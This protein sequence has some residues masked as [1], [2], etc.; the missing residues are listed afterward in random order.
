M[1]LLAASYAAVSAV[2]Y[3][4]DRDSASVLWA[5]GLTLAAIGAATLVSGATL[6]IVWAAEAA[7][8]AWL[9]RRIDEPRFQ[10][11]SLGWLALAFVHALAVDARVTRL[12]VANDHAY[13]AV[14]SVGAL[15][16]AA[17]LIGLSRFE[18]ETRDEGLLARMFSDLR[19]AQ[20]HLH[21]AALV[22]AGATALYAGSL[23]V[24]AMPA[25]WDWGHV[26]VAG[27]WSAVAAGLVVL[28]RK[29]E[30]LALSLAALLL[31]VFYDLPH[32]AET[33]RAWSF[34]CVGAAA[35]V[36]AVWW[37]LRAC[38][39]TM[40]VAALVEL[41]ASVALTTSSVAQLLDGRERG[42]G[43]L[44][45]AAAYG[46]TAVLLLRRRRDFASGLG[47]VALALAVPAS[48]LLLH[49]TWL[50][51]AWAATSAALVVLTR[52]EQ[53]LAYGAL[54]YF[55]LALLHTLALDAPPS[56]LF[57]AH[58]H[59][60]TG[61]PTLA[62]SALA[63]AVL[64]LR[65]P[66]LRRRLGWLAGALGLYAVALA[67]LEASEAIGGGIDTAFQRGHTAVSALWG[68]IGLTLLVAG[69]KRSARHLQFGGFALFGVA[70]AKLFLYD[71]G[72]LS[73]ITR[74]LS[75]LAVGA[76]MIVGGFF[77]QR[78]ALESRT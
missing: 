9:A 34:A 11:A 2:L 12:F 73:S 63:A 24:V 40:E 10:L 8:L 26:A 64:A 69:L 59:P 72:H 42:A 55:G 16:A 33:P 25:S 32:V 71:L 14:P 51:L 43:L 15:A 53:R 22:L 67:L 20:P 56:T 31:V 78:L 47:V 70:L 23:G 49:A 60:G 54:T 39:R 58:R 74:A 6:T 4:R 7:L 57:V 68:V 17:A 46:L 35:L 76:V 18:W 21:R 45:L 19:D 29:V 36:V 1:L 62:L 52:L 66:G 48:W 44:G 30:A 5:I 75:F 37:E 77:Y 38:V 3:R 27:L 28:R 50:V 13:G 65:T 41:V 61:A